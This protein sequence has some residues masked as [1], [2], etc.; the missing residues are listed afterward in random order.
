MTSLCTTTT[1]LMRLNSTWSCKKNSSFW[2]SVQMTSP[3]Q[4]I[5]WG[6]TWHHLEKKNL[7]FWTYVQITSPPQLTLWDWTRHHLAKKTLHF[8]HPSRWHH[9][10]SLLYKVELD[11]ILRKKNSLFWTYVQ[12]TSP[13]QLTLRGW[14]RHHLAKKP[15]HFERS[16]RWHHH[17]NLP[18]EIELDIILRKKNSILNIRPDEITTTA[19]FMRLNSTSS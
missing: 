12:M 5:S 11:I 3:P 18:Y 4:L 8:E 15:L 10:H 2:T 16:S 9:H 19:Y 1:Y 7:P 17:H 13:P 14:T 6:W